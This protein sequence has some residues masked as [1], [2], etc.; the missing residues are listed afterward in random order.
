M[1][2]NKTFKIELTAEQKKKLEDSGVHLQYG[3]I[4]DR[5]YS[6]RE[7]ARIC[8]YAEAWLRTCF[9]KGE[10]PAFKVKSGNRS[11]WAMKGADV[12]KL[13][14]E[15][16]DKHLNRLANGGKGKGYTYRRPTEWASYLVEK[17]IRDDK[18]LTADQ[19]K[20][21]R[22]AMKRYKVAWD[23]AYEE[24]LAKKAENAAKKAQNAK[25]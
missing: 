1:A 17:S 23:K 19:K 2:E 8:D 3:E 15:Q 25:K 20:L 7:V 4:H 22:T 14:Q 24:R 12:A 13:R 11:V 18:N 16:A 9:K 21:M 10:M 5:N 6:L